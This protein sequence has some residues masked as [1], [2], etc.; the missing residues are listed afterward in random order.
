MTRTAVGA[1]VDDEAEAEGEMGSVVETS[2]VEEARVVGAD[3]V[4]TALE[5]VWDY[6]SP[7]FQAKSQN[8]LTVSAKMLVSN[9]LELVVAFV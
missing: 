3:A 9:G 7:S 4:E 5:L 8:F 1:A 2:R 6:I